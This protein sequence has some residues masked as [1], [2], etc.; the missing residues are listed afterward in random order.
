MWYYLCFTYKALPL[1]VQVSLISQ[2]ALHDI[3]AV[4]DARFDWSQTSAMRAVH[5]FHNGTITLQAQRN[6]WEKWPLGIYPWA[7]T[8]VSKAINTASFGR[9][10]PVIKALQDLLASAEQVCYHFP[11]LMK[12]VCFSLLSPAKHVICMWIQVIYY[13]R[14]T[15]K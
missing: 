15:L 2:A 6:L 13:I 9:T 1:S 7:N 14:T 4:I 12:L 3:L 5:Q 10:V 8:I 11:M